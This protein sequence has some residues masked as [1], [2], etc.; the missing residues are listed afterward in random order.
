MRRSFGILSLLQFLPNLKEA[1]EDLQRYVTPDSLT[2][3]VPLNMKT[4]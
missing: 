2:T 3:Q 1:K 4:F